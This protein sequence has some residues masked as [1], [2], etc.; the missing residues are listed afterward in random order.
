[1]IISRKYLNLNRWHR[2][3]G[4]TSVLLVMLLSGTGLLLNHTEE[5][6]LA[7]RYVQSEWVLDWYGIQ[8]P[9]IYAAFPLGNETTPRWLSAIN[10]QLYLD[11]EPLSGNYDN[12]QGAVE[13]L[14]S[15]IAV[16]IDEQILLLTIEGELVERL[17]PLQGLPTGINA[18]GLNSEQ[19]L[20]VR[21]SRGIYQPDSEFIGWE[22]LSDS[23]D[24][25][26]WVLPQSPP[27]NLQQVLT[28]QIRAQI[29]PWER[30]LLDLHSGRLFGTWGVY[31]IDAA[32]ILFLV[33]AFTGF[34]IW[35]RYIRRS[36]LSNK[37]R[38][39]K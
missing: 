19:Q 27:K 20:Q 31:F 25:V 37:K 4:L 13:I 9:K 10:D 24:L 38:A 18:L 8:T 33:L 26:Q 14:E 5:L 17:T 23:P 22:K 1:V 12:L 11:Q 2:Y 36:N 21:T 6:Q 32:A 16:L 34:F 39:D 35:L 29:L 30:V 7:K 15:F 28:A 3:M